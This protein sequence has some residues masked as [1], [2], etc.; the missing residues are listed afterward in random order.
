LLV[1]LATTMTVP[2][3][4]TTL[5][6][7]LMIGPPAAARALTTNPGGAIG[8]STVIAVAIAWGAIAL[9][10]NTDWPIGFFVGALSATAYTVARLIQS[11]AQ[12]V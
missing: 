11:W 3:V 5:I 10:Y 7:S 9:S 4:G 1:A 6:F 2:V 8:L 12:N